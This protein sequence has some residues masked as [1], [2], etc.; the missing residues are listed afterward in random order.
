M[1]EKEILAEYL[2]EKVVSPVYNWIIRYKIHLKI[3]RS[4]STKLGDYSPPGSRRSYHRITVNHDLNPYAFFITFVHELAHL[5]T[6]KRYGRV[7]KA[8]GK[9]WKASYRR[10]LEPFLEK[11][12][13]PYE[14]Q[15][16]VFQHLQNI[17]ASSHADVELTR[18]LM[19]FDGKQQETMMED[20]QAGDVFLFQGNRRF[21]VV[22]KLRKRFKC[23]ELDT[24]RV[25]LFQPLTP[26]ELISEKH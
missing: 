2:P 14:L 15:Y 21:Q 11:N 25:F 12:V 26:V 16:A 1:K 24:Q 10:L 3:T 23:L 19:L 20:L 7:A 4:R 5:L 13:F 17:K 6:F 9:E 22:T 8:H 18:T